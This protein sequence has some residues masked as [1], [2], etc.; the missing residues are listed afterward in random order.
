MLA[1]AIAACTPIAVVTCGD[2]PASP[3]PEYD[4]DIPT[5]WEPAVTN[6]Y[7]PL[8]PGTVWR[9]EG[10]TAEGTETIVVEV[11]QGTREVNGVAATAVRDR[12]FLDGEPIE[13]TEDWF[14]QDAAGNVWYL[15]ED[16][17][18]IE[19]G[20]VVSTAGSWT[21]GR[22]GALP[23]IVMWADPAAHQGEEYRQEYFAGEAEDWGKVISA[24]ERVEVPAGGFD[25]CVR[26]E[27]WNPLEPAAPREHK[28]YC[29]EVGL[30]LEHPVG[31]NERVELVERTTPAEGGA[32]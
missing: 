18:D 32:P 19:G 26:T 16:S 27:D 3:G 29:P 14:A 1:A 20:E 5:A 12:V 28:Y 25:G 17:K 11:L 24:A 15:G 13:D 21:W 7:F 9:Y 22:D 4:P 23:G 8:V 31:G 6:R 10:E 30:V 2:D